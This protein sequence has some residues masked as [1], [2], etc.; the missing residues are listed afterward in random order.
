MRLA[1]CLAY[2]IPQTIDLAV[3]EYSQNIAHT[4]DGLALEGLLRRL[5]SMPS[6]PAVVL[7]SLPARFVRSQRESAGQ[8]W[9]EPLAAH[10][11]LPLLRMV[12]L[13]RLEGSVHVHPEGCEPPTVRSA[14]P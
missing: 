9:V 14:R 2:Q 13:L 10:Y 11:D 6:A 7:L 1:Q 4:H 8:R 3:V 12:D 5:L